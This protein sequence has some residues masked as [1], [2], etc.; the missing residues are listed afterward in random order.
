MRH[1]VSVII[2]E[3]LKIPKSTAVKNHAEMC[4]VTRQNESI[5]KIVCKITPPPPPTNQVNR[6]SETQA[7]PSYAPS[8]ILNPNLIEKR[9]Q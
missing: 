7:R 8:P 4:F 5:A 2:T 6:R 3:R 9:P 1:P